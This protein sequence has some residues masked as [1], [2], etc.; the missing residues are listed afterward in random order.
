[1]K[2]YI[3]DRYNKADGLK[4][5]DM[6][7]PK[8]LSDQVLVEIRSIA[9]NDWDYAIYMG[10]PWILRMGNGLFKPNSFILVFIN[11]KAYNNRNS[12]K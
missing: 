9:L 2:A 4:L 11:A 8:P 5:V 10:K 1:M 3:L 12:M 7:T 6:K